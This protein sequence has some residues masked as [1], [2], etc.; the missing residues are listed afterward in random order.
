MATSSEHNRGPVF[1][2]RKSFHRERRS[3]A[4]VLCCYAACTGPS[5]SAQES[6]CRG[7]KQSQGS[8]LTKVT[9]ASLSLQP[10]PLA[11]ARSLPVPA[12]QQICCRNASVSRQ[13]RPG[14]DRSALDKN[15]SGHAQ[16]AS[17][18]PTLP[19]GGGRAS[20]STETTPQAV[21]QV[22]TSHLKDGS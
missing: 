6:Q 11:K 18:V 8:A 16:G 21:E 5:G 14:S 13:L 4:F 17:P 20:Q 1:P 9:F 12:L 15:K 2:W 7:L 3:T 22:G 10:C 19:C